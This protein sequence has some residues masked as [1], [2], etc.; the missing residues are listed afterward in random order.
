MLHHPALDLVEVVELID[1]QK[2]LPVVERVRKQRGTE[3][4]AA[5]AQVGLEQITCAQA[6]GDTQRW[7][8][9]SNGKREAGGSPKRSDASGRTA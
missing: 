3:R 2:Q 9:A 8:A 7:G 5:L 6:A 1:Q 4:I